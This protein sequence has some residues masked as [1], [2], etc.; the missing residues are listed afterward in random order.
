MAF[1]FKQNPMRPTPHH[2]TV[3]VGWAHIR[4]ATTMCIDMARGLCHVFNMY[5]LHILARTTTCNVVHA[6]GVGMQMVKHAHTPTMYGH[7]FLVV[8][9]H[10]L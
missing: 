5:F 1:E 2:N 3:V 9:Q 4:S 6:I 8:T 7:M 10:R